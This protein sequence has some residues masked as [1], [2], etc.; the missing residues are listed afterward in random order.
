MFIE[1]R[2]MC[3]RDLLEEKRKLSVQEVSNQLNVSVDTVR[4]DFDKLT[5]LNECTRTH[6]G[7]ILKEAS[8][9]EYS[10]DERRKLHQKEK[11]KIA[12]KAAELI[13][14]SEVVIIDAGTTALEMVRFLDQKNDLTI[15]TNGLN[16][17]MEIV[18]FQYQHLQTILLGG[19]LRQKTLTLTGHDTIS[20][21]KH[22]HADKMFLSAT[23]FSHDFGLSNPNRYE[24]EIRKQLIEISEQLIVVADHTK[25]NRKA[26]Y[27]EGSVEDID[28]LIT[29]S[30]AEEEYLRGLEALGI[31]ILIT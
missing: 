2:L 24:A 1:E 12:K 26:L 15:L 9:L 28:I 21:L 8:V 27:K 5:E 25:L 16:I 30:L 22:Y 11:R 14:E 29:D 6:G 23:A 17:A 19:N 18:K 4:R 3:I 7:I 10:F 20:V 13:S 31:E